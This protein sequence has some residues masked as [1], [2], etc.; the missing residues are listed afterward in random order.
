MP[1]EIFTLKSPR[2][3]GFGPH[4]QSPGFNNIKFAYSQVKAILKT[5]YHR[6]NDGRPMHQ[7]SIR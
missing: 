1:R 2:N 4:I 5:M 6:A 7:I 3:R